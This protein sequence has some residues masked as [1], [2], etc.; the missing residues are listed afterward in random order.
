MK[1]FVLCLTMIDVNALLHPPP[2]A[3]GLNLVLSIGS[4][5]SPKTKLALKSFFSCGGMLFDMIRL[6]NLKTVSAYM[7]LLFWVFAVCCH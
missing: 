6:K 2:I 7:F 5:S 1:I 3:T 4:F